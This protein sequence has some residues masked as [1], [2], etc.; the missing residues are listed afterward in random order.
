MQSFWRAKLGLC[1]SFLIFLIILA[2][3]GLFIAFSLFVES[4][5]KCFA[6]RTSEKPV[7][8]NAGIEMNEL[9]QWNLNVGIATGVIELIRNSVNI[10][11]K[12]VNKKRVAVVFQLLGIF[13]VISFLFN[14]VLMH[15]YYF[16]HTGK[17]CASD[18]EGLTRS[19]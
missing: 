8:W 9:Y 16:S 19:S 2:H 10:C 1:F 4:D 12:C 7:Q 5:L 11:L 3:T 18:E 15:L 17:V 6:N 13:T 14:L